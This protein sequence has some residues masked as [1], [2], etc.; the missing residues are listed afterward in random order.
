MDH[1]D[2]LA[3]IPEKLRTNPAQSLEDGER[4]ARLEGSIGSP[5]KLLSGALILGSCRCVSQ[6]GRREFIVAFG[7]NAGISFPADAAIQKDAGASRGVDIG[8]D[9][10]SRFGAHRRFLSAGVRVVP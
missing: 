1:L 6:V 7:L 9:K 4:A 2:A 5:T 10:E 8:G 3:L